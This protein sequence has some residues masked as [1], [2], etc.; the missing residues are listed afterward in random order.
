MVDCRFKRGTIRHPEGYQAL[1]Q[2]DSQTRT[3]SEDLPGRTK[4]WSPYF[5]SILFGLLIIAADQFTKYLIWGSVGPGGTRIDIEITSWFRFIFVR[6]TG[7]AFGLFQGQ[8]SIL[9]IL[10]FVALGFLAVV[11][12]RHARNDPVTALAL[13]LI[14]GGAIG[15]LIDRL[16]LGYVIDWIDVPRFPTFNVA[17]SAITVGV[18][19]LMFALLF[20]AQE[21]ED[22]TSESDESPNRLNHETVDTTE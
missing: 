4:L 22:S 3:Q 9:A 1:I 19:L 14:V 21:I 6:N 20:R 5:L 15:N 10:S 18:S 7:S 13:G 11:F 17:D 8:T 12:H 2:N 16:R